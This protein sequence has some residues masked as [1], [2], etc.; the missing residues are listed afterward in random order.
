MKKLSLPT[1]AV[2]I[3][4]LSGCAGGSLVA[5][6]S[7]LCPSVGIN[8]MEPDFSQSHSNEDIGSFYSCMRYQLRGS[9]VP[10]PALQ[11]LIAGP[12]ATSLFGDN[13][14][15]ARLRTD[16]D[17]QESLWGQISTREITPAAAQKD[18]L[19]W[20]QSRLLVE[21]NEAQARAA[22][23][24]ANNSGYGRGFTCM[25]TGNMMHCN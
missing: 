9:E 16:L 4:L 3:P 15:K 24:A 22:A 25:G 13:E 17:Y 12:F 2:L 5:D 19:H 1:L 10:P 18:W 21:A 8:I 7:K 6:A 20:E 14:R 23:R 11:V